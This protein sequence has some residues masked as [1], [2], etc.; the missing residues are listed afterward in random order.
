VSVTAAQGAREGQ[1]DGNPKKDEGSS[2][3][4]LQRLTDVS[5][6]LFDKALDL[7][8]RTFTASYEL[9]TQD[10][11]ECVE[12]GKYLMLVQ[13]TEDDQDVKALAV[14]GD[15]E[16]YNRSYCLLDYFVV[17]PRFRGGGYGAKFFK[18]VVDYLHFNTPYRIMLL[19]CDNGL[20]GWY[21]RLGAKRCSIPSSMCLENADDDV[22]DLES[23][24]LMAISVSNEDDVKS[25]AEPETLRQVVVHMRAWL[26]DLPNYEERVCERN[27]TVDSYLVW[28]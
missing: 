12:Q 20:M 3:S 6:A 23:F 7:Y 4:H 2:Q 24:N 22:T 21:S 19:E 8:A 18:V 26:H 14:L 10:L 28:W 15:L 17:D 13:K 1:V 25:E 5:S 9:S 16:P 27:G 11:K